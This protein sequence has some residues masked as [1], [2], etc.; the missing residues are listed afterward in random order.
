MARY[1]ERVSRVFLR[2]HGYR[3]RWADTGVGRLHYYERPGDPAQPPLVL[4]HGISASGTSFGPLLR[5]L[6]WHRG[7]VL[8]PDF[9]GHGFSHV[10]DA[11]DVEVIFSG[12][13]ELLEANLAGPATVLGNSLGGAMALRL[14][15]ERPHAVRMLVLLSPAGAPVDHAE[16][17]ALLGMFRMTTIA[18]ARA[19]TRR[20]YHRT[21]W[22]SRL[23]AREVLYLFRRPCIQQILDGIGPDDHATPDQLAELDLPILLAWGQSDHILP[24]A[25][26]D[27]F[28][29][30]LPAHADIV[31]PEA[32]SH[33]PYLEHP[34]AV[35]EMVREFVHRTRLLPAP[36]R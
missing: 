13:A 11:L 2:R 15:H 6:H 17:E 14:A 5:R 31:E 20:I 26:L 1:Y 8:V 19:F 30:H 4:L 3:S 7:Q 32:F 24:R 23:V 28:R 35:A 9:P 36:R 29:A 18:D 10:P 34:R 22:Y 25:H 12:L 33:N 16:R 21:P 27:Y